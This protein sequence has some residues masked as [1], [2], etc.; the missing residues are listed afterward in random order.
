[1]LP[2]TQGGSLEINLEFGNK[3][4][5]TVWRMR[6]GKYLCQLISGSNRTKTEQDLLQVMLHKMEIYLDIWCAHE[7]SLW[8][9][10]M[11]LCLSQ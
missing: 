3:S 10:L 4:M 2:Q 7:T 1:M 8:A 5:K 11:V 6:P 9:I